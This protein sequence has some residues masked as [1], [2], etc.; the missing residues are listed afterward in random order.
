[1]VENPMIKG[2][3]AGAS[4]FWGEKKAEHPCGKCNEEREDIDFD[5]C[6]LCIGREAQRLIAELVA[7]A[8]MDVRSNPS[9]ENR[10][11]Q[12]A[13]WLINKEMFT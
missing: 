7:V 8:T 13:L 10:M 9:E 12:N 6:D 4:D 11:R 3:D 5:Y 1:M 2:S